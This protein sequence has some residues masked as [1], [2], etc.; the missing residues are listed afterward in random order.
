MSMQ[1]GYDI[2]GTLQHIVI[3][4]SQHTIAV[5]SQ[6]CGSLRI[7]ARLQRMLPPVDLDHQLRLGHKKSTIYPWIGTCLRKRKPSICL[8]RRHRHNCCSASV[9][10]LR[11]CLARRLLVSIRAGP[12]VDVDVFTPPQPSPSPAAKGRELFRAAISSEECP[13]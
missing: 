1:I 9:I 8:A 4:V 3:P 5:P 2:L 7:I 13:K 12:V 6:R 10:A 11:N